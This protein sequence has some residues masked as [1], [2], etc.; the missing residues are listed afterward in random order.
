MTRFSISSVSSVP[1][2]FRICGRSNG[3]R[4]LCGFLVMVFLL[5]G[6]AG[7][8]EQTTLVGDVAKAYDKAQESMENGNYRGAIQIFEA[9][10]A[11][12]PFSEISKQVQLE[13]MYA[14]YKIGQK[15][16]AIDT[17]DQF[18]RENP[19]HPRV[20]YPIYIKGLTHF[21]QDKGL[22]ERMFRKDVA[23]RP[24]AD[25]ELAFSLFSRLV[26]R[27]PTSE[28]APDARQR[29]VF[30]KNRLAAYENSVA[31]YYL[32][33]GAYIAALNRAKGAIEHYNGSDSTQE[34]LQLMI[35]AY[36]GLGMHELARDTQRVLD[37]N[38][39]NDG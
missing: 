22:L 8:D 4:I 23:G 30:L 29:M 31:R 1:A 11:R 14:Y 27:Y 16:Q 35:T 25:A 9:L 2:G 21:E 34:S 18:L 37:Q 7:Q 17:A 13:L 10:Q 24:P 5:A 38:A 15:E 33:T 19:T 20:D 26:E 28:H 3:L 12:F 32:K 36:E 39:S 6:C